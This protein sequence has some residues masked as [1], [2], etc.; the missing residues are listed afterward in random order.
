MNDDVMPANNAGRSTTGKFKLF[1][2]VG[3]LGGLAAALVYTFWFTAD[4]LRENIPDWTLGLWSA[5]PTY[6]VFFGLYA[7]TI[8]VGLVAAQ[9]RYLGRGVRLGHLAT[10]LVISTIC[11]IVGGFMASNYSTRLIASEDPA[12]FLGWT[13][14]GAIIGLIVATAVINLPKPIGILSGALGGFLGCGINYMLGFHPGVAA[15]GALIGFIL[16]YME[17]TNRQAWLEIQLREDGKETP[18]TIEVTIGAKPIL[19]GYGRD[20]DVRLDAL[21]GVPGDNFA[22]I[23]QR[24]NEIV[25]TDLLSNQTRALGDNTRFTLSNAAVRI[26]RK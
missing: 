15:A 23:H 2:A 4:R 24:G 25:F 8:A 12:R 18:R 1:T 13:M 10:V 3:A 26:C 11:G 22:T 21:P 17:R 16:A 6:V 14:G 19:L 9:D 20:A 7:A 5:D